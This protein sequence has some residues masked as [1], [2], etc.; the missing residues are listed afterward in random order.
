MKRKGGA[1]F[2][3]FWH[4]E[5][6]KGVCPAG[7]PRTVP[8]CSPVGKAPAGSRESSRY[9]PGEKIRFHSGSK[10][11]A[12]RK[13]TAAPCQVCRIFSRVQHL[14]ASRPVFLEYRGERTAKSPPA[15]DPRGTGEKTTLRVVRDGQQR[16]S[17]F[18]SGTVSPARLEGSGGM[19]RN[20]HS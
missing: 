5:A 16:Q 19:G 9:R 1:P 2:S 20:I 11:R 14:T 3:F 7:S 18:R 13:K 12:P 17:C 6:G 8:G 15:G 10:G 4:T